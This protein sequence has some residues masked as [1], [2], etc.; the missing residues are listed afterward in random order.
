MSTPKVCAYAIFL[1]LVSGSQQAI[2]GMEVR[3]QRG[4]IFY[5]NSHLFHRTEIFLKAQFGE[6]TSRLDEIRRLNEGR[7]DKCLH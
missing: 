6:P 1:R 7:R 3:G 4:K 5:C 2:A